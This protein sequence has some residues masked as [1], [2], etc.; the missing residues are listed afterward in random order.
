MKSL[1]N[2]IFEQNSNIVQLFNNIKT[3]KSWKEFSSNLPKIIGNNY[4]IKYINYLNEKTEG[5]YIS[6]ENTKGSPLL[7]L[8]DGDNKTITDIG[9]G[10]IP[11]N[12]KWD[13]YENDYKSEI[14]KSAFDNKG[15]TQHSEYCCKIPRNIFDEIIGFVKTIK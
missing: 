4:E 8:L 11:K 9:F 7:S 10:I 13:V 1:K 12:K 5:C 14:I 15:Y 2:F 3:I 6:R